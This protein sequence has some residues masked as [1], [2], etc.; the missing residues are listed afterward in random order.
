MEAPFSTI[1]VMA[2]IFCRAVKDVLEKSTQKTIIYSNTIQRIPKVSLRPALGCF[3]IF[4]GDY[5]G[6]AVMN[7]TAE[8]AMDIYTSS[9]LTMGMP[10]EECAKSY[11]SGEVSD[12]IGELVNQV[13]GQSMALVEQ[14]F[15]LASMF[16]QPKALVLNNAITLSID[17]EY[18]DN[19]RIV[20]SIG[21]SSRFSME[22]A[23]EQ[24]E[25]IP[26]T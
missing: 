23:M 10:E 13:M 4:N 22:I 18:R 12:S 3:V 8:A 9:M 15:D 17:S 5:N 14:K 6:L 20:F 1:D 19:R 16:G 24:T 11:T 2:N 25:F 26:A 21:G 7:F